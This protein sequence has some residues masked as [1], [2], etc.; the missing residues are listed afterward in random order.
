MSTLSA[1]KYLGAYTAGQ[2]DFWMLAGNQKAT[3]RAHVMSEL[4][5]KKM[6]QS[7]SGVTALREA[8]YAIAK[9]EGNCLAIQ[10]KSFVEWAK[11]QLA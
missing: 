4:M 1:L 3:C 2:F 8:F 5:G 6:P 10:E 9:P 11:Q 7:K